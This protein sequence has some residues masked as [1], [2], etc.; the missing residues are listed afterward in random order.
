[1]AQGLNSLL[2]PPHLL[3]SNLAGL[4]RVAIGIGQFL[5]PLPEQAKDPFEAG[6]APPARPPGRPRLGQERRA[7]NMAGRFGGQ[8]GRRAEEQIRLLQTDFST[9]CLPRAHF[10]SMVKE[11]LEQLS[12][13]TDDKGGKLEFRISPGA[14]KVLQSA[15]EAKSR[16]KLFHVCSMVLSFQVNTCCFQ[17]VE[18]T[19]L[20][21]IPT[22]TLSS[23]HIF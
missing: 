14:L 15:V 23:W 13:P 19:L 21:V 16:L 4:P 8:D 9:P 11:T 3:P 2:F 10:V 22:V 18:S 20:R 6:E 12:P 1:M 5:K 17:T 7:Y